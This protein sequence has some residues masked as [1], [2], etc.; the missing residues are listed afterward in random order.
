MKQ[1]RKHPF[2][3]VVR[4]LLL[5]VLSLSLS[6]CS[7]GPRLQPITA[8]AT[9]LAFGDSLTYGTGTSRD[10]AYPAVLETLINRKVINAGVPGEVTREG[11]VRLPQL[12]SRHQ[13]DLLIL[14]HGGNDILRKLDMVKAKNNI[15]QMIDLA[16]EQQIQVMLIGVPEFGLF[17]DPAPIYQEIAEENNLPILSDA[18]SD[19][20]S[21][22]QLKSDHI[23]PNSKGYQQLAEKIS[24]ML[25]RS[26]AVAAH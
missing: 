18:L 24:D 12:L 25:V 21:S 1:G 5:L 13:P 17:L 7:D 15:Q 6:A 26:K 3:I 2:H 16:R 14:C 19:I 10:K 8:D 23:H 4:T 22:S 9:I 11:L 20:L